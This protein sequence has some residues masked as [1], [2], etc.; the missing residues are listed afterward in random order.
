MPYRKHEMPTYPCIADL[1]DRL[2]AEK[3]PIVV[4]GMGNGAD[5]LFERLEKY[6]V[7]PSDIFASDGFV[8][9]HSY[10]GMRVLSFSEIKEK[11][12]DF[13]ILLSFASRREEVL[14]LLSSIDGEHEMYIPDMPVAGEEYFDRE[15]YNEHYRE[16]CAARDSL[17]DEESRDAFC[18]ILNYKLTGR[19]RYLEDAYSEKSEL[20]DL[21]GKDTERY[22]DVGAY[23]GDTL[24]EAIEH[25][26]RLRAAVAVEPDPRT[27]RRLEKYVATIGDIDV[28]TVNAAAWE[29][30]GEGS[31]ISSS[32]RNSSVNSTSSYQHRDTD[33]VLVAPDS[34]GF[35]ADFIKYDVEGA[36]AEALRGSH[37]MIEEGH[38]TLLVSLYHRSRDIF[39]LTNYLKEKYPFYRIYL[40][41][42]RCVPAWE[43]ALVLKTT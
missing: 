20:Y 24:R 36:E 11:Y 27:F 3:R 8:R 26:P 38:P 4:Y 17:A 32:N 33:V 37:R 35:E 42:T 21:I 18:A 5:K 29:C 6:G 19:M 39:A 40:R 14:E 23:N 22:L 16:L 28:R 9:G 31:F 12:H 7:T 13:V 43:I 1:W 25:F 10:R 30:D 34:L 15:F 41:R 2:A